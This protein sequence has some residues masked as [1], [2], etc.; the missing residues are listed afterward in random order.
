MMPSRP[1]RRCE[2]DSGLPFGRPAEQR[3]PCSPAPSKSETR[4]R[5]SLAGRP[6]G[7]RRV[8]AP[9]AATVGAAPRRPHPSR[10]RRGG[11]PR[12]SC[13]ATPRRAAGLAC[14]P[15]NDP[16][17]LPRRRGT[18][19]DH[20][21]HHRGIDSD[22]STTSPLRAPRRLDHP[23]RRRGPRAPIA[24]AVACMTAA[25]ILRLSPAAEAQRAADID[26]RLRLGGTLGRD[27]R[28]SPKA[29]AELPA[30]PGQPGQHRTETP[31]QEHQPLALDG[32]RETEQGHRL[33]GCGRLRRLAAGGTE[34][35]TAVLTRAARRLGD[36]V[37]SAR[38]G[39]R[40]GVWPAGAGHPPARRA[41]P[42]EGGR[43][44]PPLNRYAPTSARPG[45]SASLTWPC[46]SRRNSA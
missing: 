39:A 28:R 41:L 32:R 4:T 2:A 45:W 44:G 12:G 15:V 22:I 6:P 33:D 14:A 19:L 21:R 37:F 23:C 30:H 18:Q 8:R 20:S 43:E 31:E 27:R 36:L 24:T 42:D 17:L 46:G 29:P 9:C 40:W 34:A 5:L 3:R 26:H 16:M 13:R 11:A 25:E 38:R 1:R 7:Q 35:R 10:R